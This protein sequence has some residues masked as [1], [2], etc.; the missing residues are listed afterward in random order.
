MQLA[1]AKCS[2]V[3]Y[4]IILRDGLIWED[5]KIMETLITVRKTD[6]LGVGFA[7]MLLN[8]NSLNCLI[9]GGLTVLLCKENVCGNRC[10]KIVQVKMVCL[11]S[12]YHTSSV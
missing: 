1:S 4:R 9:C 6:I 5:I 3:L 2:F 11:N 7:D 10:S 8:V 12:C